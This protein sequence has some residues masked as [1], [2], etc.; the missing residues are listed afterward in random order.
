MSQLQWWHR[1]EYGRDL[2]CVL[3]A[4]ELRVRYRNTVLG[5]VWSVLHPLLFVV[6]YYLV[7]KI[8]LRFSTDNYALFLVSVIF[9]GVLKSG[10]PPSLGLSTYRE[11]HT[12]CLGLMYHAN[13][14]ASRVPLLGLPRNQ[15]RKKLMVL[16]H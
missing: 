15:C 4:K 2:I 6:V 9:P 7:F 1:L 13:Q 10:E 16:G 8:G 3:I 11:Q 5:Y 12:P 14:R